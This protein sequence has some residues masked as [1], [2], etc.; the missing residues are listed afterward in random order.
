[1]LW[2]NFKLDR[3]QSG[4]LYNPPCCIDLMF[5]LGM[6]NS[7]NYSANIPNNASSTYCPD[8]ID[9]LTITSIYSKHAWNALIAK[10]SSD[11]S[12][13]AINVKFHIQ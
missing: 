4:I 8:S 12:W 2:L 10:P 7:R 13:S 5:S 1:M 3:R 11:E 9:L 6:I